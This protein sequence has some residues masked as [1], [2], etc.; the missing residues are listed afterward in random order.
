[1]TDDSP[2][3]QTTADPAQRALA[4]AVREIEHHVA[5]AG[6][7]A[8][9]RVFALVRTQAA[10]AAEPGLAA[11]LTPEVLAAAAAEPWHLTSIEQEELPGAP[12]LESL[13]AGLTW[14]ESVDGAAVTVERI[15]LPPAA[16]QHVPDDEAAALEYLLTHPE[17]QDVRLAVGVLRGGAA[18][19]A[20]RTRANDADDAVGHGPDLVPGLV[21]A[22]RST[23]A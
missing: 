16:E 8:P 10:L 7:D 3:P 5:A 9:V 2:A 20:V 14:P 13:L 22:V 11:Q 23:L 4:D 21:A 17:R 15:V 12:D 1:M 18:W 19:C 6:W